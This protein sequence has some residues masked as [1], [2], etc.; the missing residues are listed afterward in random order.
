M[1]GGVVDTYPLSPI[2]QGMLFHHLEDAHAGIDIEQLVIEYTELPDVARLERAWQATLARHPVMRT[3]FRWDSQPVQ[4]VHATAPL[5]IERRDGDLMA[6]LA[7]DRTRG[8]DLRTPPL[9]R[10]TLVGTTLVWTLHH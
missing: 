9:M 1:G 8:F 3:A 5:A 10:L 7:A 6:F 2:Q 4:E